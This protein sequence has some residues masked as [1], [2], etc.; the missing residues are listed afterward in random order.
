M[1]YLTACHDR[2]AARMRELMEGDAARA[3]AEMDRAEA[4]AAGDR[5]THLRAP[6]R[7]APLWEPQ[8]AMG[9]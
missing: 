7:E 6:L 1:V 4:V 2:D 5:I 8:P 3:S 9:G